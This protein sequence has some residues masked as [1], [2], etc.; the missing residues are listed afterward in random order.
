MSGQGQL[1]GGGDWLRGAM[2]TV[3][4]NLQNQGVGQGQSEF[5][6]F[7]MPGGYAAL[8][9]VG[10]MSP[11]TQNYA[12]GQGS[13][14]Q[15]YQQSIP[16][17]MPSTV[18]MGQGQLNSDAGGMLSPEL[19]SSSNAVGGMQGI[20]AM[21]PTAVQNFQSGG[22]TPQYQSEYNSLGIFRACSS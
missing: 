14:I 3:M 15:N 2:A 4:S 7:G 19:Q 10:A 20:G 5:N 12:T 22:W 17:L 16:G 13:A 11:Y 8:Q 21:M 6:Q 9:G 18:G 1:G